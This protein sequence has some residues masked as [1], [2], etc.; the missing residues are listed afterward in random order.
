M[1]L[2]LALLGKVYFIVE[3]GLKGLGEAGC[4][5]YFEGI[6]TSD[7]LSESGYHSNAPISG[8]EP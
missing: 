5:W 1:S 7:M 4:I 3:M 8:A 2:T 6:K